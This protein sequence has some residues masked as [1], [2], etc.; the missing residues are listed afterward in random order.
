MTTVDLDEIRARRRKRVV[1]LHGQEFEVRRLSL[2]ILESLDGADDTNLGQLRRLIEALFGDGSW[3]HFSSCDVDELRTII[4]GLIPG[5]LPEFEPDDP[6]LRELLEGLSGSKRR[7]VA[8]GARVAPGAA[9]GDLGAG[10][11]V[12]GSR[13]SA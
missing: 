4:K 10:G 7:Q 13:G 11:D 12:D 8:Q 6:A 1:R 5:S 3:E 9:N 2:G